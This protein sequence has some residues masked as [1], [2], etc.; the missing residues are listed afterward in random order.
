MLVEEFI[1]LDRRANCIVDSRLDR[2]PSPPILQPDLYPNYLPPIIIGAVWVSIPAGP[3]LH[4][5]RPGE[6]FR[7]RAATGAASSQGQ[8]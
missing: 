4:H 6:L 1:E 8:P 2:P 3:Q 5:G 7:R